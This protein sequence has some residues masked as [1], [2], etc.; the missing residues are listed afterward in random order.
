MRRNRG[1]PARLAPPCFL[2]GVFRSRR[3]FAV[4]GHC[5][6]G[7]VAAAI[8]VERI[9]GQ[10]R[11]IMPIGPSFVRR[12]AIQPTIRFWS[13]PSRLGGRYRYHEHSGLYAG[14]RNCTGRM[15]SSPARC[16]YASKKG[17]RNGQI[18]VV[19]C[20]RQQGETTGARSM[21]YRFDLQPSL[22]QANSDAVRWSR[23]YLRPIAVTR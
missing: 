2:L 16:F 21:L 13:A 6:S 22:V 17:R 20:G 8:F 14:M 5:A 11:R 3:T 19:A 10:A 18:S 1:Q 4:S 12:S 9:V 15:P 23:R 7:P